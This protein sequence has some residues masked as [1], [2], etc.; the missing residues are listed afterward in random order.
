MISINVD[1]YQIKERLENPEACMSGG[2]EPI[3]TFAKLLGQRIVYDSKLKPEHRT[4]TPIALNLQAEKLL[5]D[6][7]SDVD[8]RRQNYD[9]TLADNPDFVYEVLAAELPNIVEATFPDDFSEE[10]KQIRKEME[11]IK[12]SM[13]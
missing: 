2:S 13:S 12:A 8:L 10:F 3:Y 6:L 11:A 7:S 4:I 9:N 1:E 5:Y